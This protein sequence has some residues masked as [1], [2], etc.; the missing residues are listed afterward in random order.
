MIGKSTR[1]KIL[2]LISIIFISCMS[3]EQKAEMNKFQQIGYVK[4]NQDRIQIYTFDYN[5]ISS[6]EVSRHASNI[7]NTPG[8]MTSV[9]YFDKN[10]RVPYNFFQSTF[11]DKIALAVDALYESYQIDDW[12]YAYMQFNTG[13]QTFVDCTKAK[14][15]RSVGLCRGDE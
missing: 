15:D 12:K 11:D 1:L 13:A 10:G 6:D 4:V 5:L 2:L 9:Y 3:E 14:S 7:I 8:K